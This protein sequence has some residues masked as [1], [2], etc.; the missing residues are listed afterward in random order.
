MRLDRLIMSESDAGEER[1]PEGDELAAHRERI[2]A[3]IEEDR[4][5]LDALDN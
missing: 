2:R 5:I 1:A 3:L 4:D